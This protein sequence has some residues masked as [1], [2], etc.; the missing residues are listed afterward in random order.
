MLGKLEE[1]VVDE[2]TAE[3]RSRARAS[4]KAT[5]SLPPTTPTSGSTIRARLQAKVTSNANLLLTD[6]VDKY[7][8]APKEPIERNFLEFW[9]L[10]SSVYPVLAEIA[11]D[12]LAACASSVPSECSFSGSGKVITA[13]RNS[14]EPV[15]VQAV[16][17]LK[18]WDALCELDEKEI[19]SLMEQ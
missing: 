16:M 12:L 10:S 5:G 6:E 9:N 13:L 8:G 17:R 4:N 15:A 18:S 11:K 3:A 2:W 7:L 14:I 19:G 1:I